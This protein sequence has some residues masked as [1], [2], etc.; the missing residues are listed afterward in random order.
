V[1]LVGRLISRDAD[2]YT[3]LPRSVKH[4]LRPEHVAQE[5]QA[6][7]LHNIKLVKRILGTAVIYVGEKPL[8]PGEEIR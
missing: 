3:Y 6:A 7:G 4:F 5:M 1:P 8:V 2:A